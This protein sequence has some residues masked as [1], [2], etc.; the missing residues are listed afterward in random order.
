[1]KLV[2]RYTDFEEITPV[3]I[4]EFVEKIVVHEREMREESGTE[5]RRLADGGEPVTESGH[6]TCGGVSAYWISISHIRYFLQ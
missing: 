1:M 2:E 4:H 6:F 5:K 3:M